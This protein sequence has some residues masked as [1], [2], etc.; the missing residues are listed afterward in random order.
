[1][2]VLIVADGIMAAEVI[3][4]ELR[5]S[6]CEVIGFVGG[7]EICATTVARQ[8]PDVIV[9]DD[10]RGEGT[11]TDIRTVRAAAP[12]AKLVLLTANMD[13][14]WLAKASQ[15]GI[16]AALAK[17]VSHASLGLLLR[18]VASGNVFHAFA[19]SAPDSAPEFVSTLTPREREILSL[20]A[21]GA[22]NSHIARALWVTEQTVKFHLS[23]I[24]RKLG[25]ANRTQASHYAFLHGLIEP[26]NSTLARGGDGTPLPA[27]A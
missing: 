23:N 22:A 19:T 27:A 10:G 11:L 17:T 20:V 12:A 4:R 3:R 13:A 5:H 24:Y 9:V 7:R 16:D 14:A 15:A 1:M 2:R 21:E 18:E 25:V 26:S 6:S 8:R